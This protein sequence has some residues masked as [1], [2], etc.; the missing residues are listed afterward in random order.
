LRCEP[1]DLF[2]G[3]S[4]TT[5][6][7]IALAELAE[8]WVIDVGRVR[9]KAIVECLVALALV[10]RCREHERRNLLDRLPED[11]HASV[12]RA[13]RDACESTNTES[14]RRQLQRLA[15]SWHAKRPARGQGC[16]RGSPR[17]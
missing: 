16:A 1:T 12:G 11:M 13:L 5:T 17:R 9:R 8:K 6:T 3:D 2:K 4:T 14:A 10:Q 7:N 15:A